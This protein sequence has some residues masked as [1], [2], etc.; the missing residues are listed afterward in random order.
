MFFINSR[1]K[2]KIA[3]LILVL[4]S[5]AGERIQT[6]AL[7]PNP[8][9]ALKH[10]QSIVNPSDTLEDNTWISNKNTVEAKIRT[11]VTQHI[12]NSIRGGDAEDEGDK[13]LVMKVIS[14]FG[15]TVFGTLFAVSRALEAGIDAI[16]EE[17]KSPI[18]KIFNAMTC[19][20]K[21][22]FD[23]NYE[24]KGTKPFSKKDFSEYLCEAYG[25][26]KPDEDGDRLKILTGTF[27]SALEKARSQAR[28]LVVFIPSSKPKK[29][30]SDQKIIESLMSD[31]V[32]ETAER[33]SRKKTDTGSFAVWSSK[34]DSADSAAAI[35]RLKAK[36]GSG[37]GKNPILM[38]VYPSPT[39]NSSGQVKIVPRV[40]VQHHCNPPPTAKSMASWLNA[41]RKR[42]A[43][44]YANMQHEL[45][46]L[47]LFKERT[48]GY[49][50][51]MKNDLKRENEEKLKEQK[52]LL[53]EKAKKEREE[54]VQKRRVTLL[55]NLA[56]E[57]ERGAKGAITIALRFHDGRQGQRRFDGDSEV[58]E[59][60]NWIDATFEIERESTII[61][62]MNGKHTFSYDEDEEGRVLNDTGLGKMAAFRVTE[63]ETEADDDGDYGE[64]SDSNSD[65]EEE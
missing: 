5:L 41:L 55:E 7:K 37:K 40:L 35:K 56:K 43:K 8:S 19:M 63:K 38:V 23:T 46:E 1:K 36:K 12:I 44:Q 59:I 21:A 6:E 24:S 25:V 32:F 58:N 14:M 34:Y 13:S 30:K 3:A 28:L 52:R 62:T 47:E 26:E 54:M 48:E 15:N 18:V 16:Q 50:S 20:V 9:F 10:V 17:G 4:L 60:F 61:T 64:Q 22:T 65:S 53:D 49:K 11:Y 42:H 51:S 29:E 2:M 45:K 39:M 33:K 31:E 57:P 27:P